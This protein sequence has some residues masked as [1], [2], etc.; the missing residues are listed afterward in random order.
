MV[1]LIK[2]MELIILVK[3]RKEDCDLRLL[4]LEIARILHFNTVILKH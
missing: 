1:R 4:F 3:T 2:N